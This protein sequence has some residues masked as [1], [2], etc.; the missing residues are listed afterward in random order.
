MATLNYSIG[1]QVANGPQIAVTRSRE[2]EAFDKL[3]VPLDPGTDVVVDLQPGAAAKVMMLLIKP[4]TAAKELTVK[5]SD[6]STDSPE[7]TLEEPQ[8]FVGDSLKLFGVDPTS[9]KLKNAFPAN[10]A[11]KKATIEIFVAR[12]ARV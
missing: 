9:L 10:D 1:I 3:D 7:L 2:I 8:L 11:T 6:G 12:K 4:S 5:V